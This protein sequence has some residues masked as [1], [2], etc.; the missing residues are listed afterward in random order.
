LEALQSDTAFRDQVRSAL[1]GDELISLP[2]RFVAFVGEM[3]DFVGEMHAFVGEMHAFVG[4]VHAFVAETNRRLGRLEDDVGSLK[5]SDLEQ[6][7]RRAPRR[8]LGA[9]LRRARTI[10]DHELD[11]LLGESADQTTLIEIDRADALVWGTLPEGDEVLGVVEVSWRVHVRDVERA[12]ERALVLARLAG[13]RV[14]PVVVSQEDPGEMVVA[15][16]ERE[17]VTLLLV[18]A[19]APLVAGRPRAA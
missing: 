11:R 10:E 2:A 14:L 19:D 7:V 17:S 4:E 6:R 8:Y 16:A 15:R 5:G 12:A 1:L 18:D 3:H 9:A 13:R